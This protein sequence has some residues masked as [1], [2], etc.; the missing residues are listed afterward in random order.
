MQR[1]RYFLQTLLEEHRNGLGREI[2]LKEYEYGET[3]WSKILK[4]YMEELE[5]SITDIKGKK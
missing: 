1:S 4:K 2:F 5:I 3:K